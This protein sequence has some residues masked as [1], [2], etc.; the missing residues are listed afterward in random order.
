MG[1]VSLGRLAVCV[2]VTAGVTACG[3]PGAP[4]RYQGSFTVLESPQHGPEMCN[5][6]RESLPP[7]CSGVPIRGWNWASVEGAESLNGTTWGRWHVTGTFDGGTF[8]LTKAPGAARAVREDAIDIQSAAGAQR[9]KALAATQEQVMERD[10]RAALGVVDSSYVDVRRR[11][12]V[13]NVW[14]ADRS[15]QRFAKERWGDLVQLR[16]LLWPAG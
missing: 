8:V 7:Q 10:A 11:V 3:G 4:S 13:V 6:V 15:A 9:E 16:S 2:V 12:V 1:V 14:L 5:G